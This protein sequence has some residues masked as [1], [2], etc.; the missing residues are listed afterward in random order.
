MPS[1]FVHNWKRKSFLAVCVGAPINLSWLIN[2]SQKSKTIKRWIDQSLMKIKNL[3]HDQLKMSRSRHFLEIWYKKALN[4][5]KWVVPTFNIHIILFFWSDSI[6]HHTYKYVQ[7]NGKVLDWVFW[8]SPQNNHFFTA[9][10]S[11]QNI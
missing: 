1:N 5:T 8:C 11:Q 6:Y 4:K 10:K 2:F 7:E 9:E 3:L